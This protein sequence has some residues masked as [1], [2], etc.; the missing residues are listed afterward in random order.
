MERSKGEI[1]PRFMGRQI[2]KIFKRSKIKLEHTIY[3]VR[4]EAFILQVKCFFKK[5]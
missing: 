1:E 4:K 3:M 2:K 5:L